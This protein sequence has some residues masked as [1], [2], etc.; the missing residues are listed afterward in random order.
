MLRDHAVET[1]HP[2]RLSPLHPRFTEIMACQREAIALRL[3]A[4]RDPS[5][6]LAVFTAVFLADRG[7]CCDSGCRHCPYIGADATTD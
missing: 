7:T 1:P 3:A 5:S 6:G 2:T 4:Y